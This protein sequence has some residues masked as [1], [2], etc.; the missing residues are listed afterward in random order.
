MKKLVIFSLTA[1]LFTAVSCTKFGKNITVK[2]RVYNPITNEGYEGATVELIRSK[3]L[4]YSGGFKEV[5]HTT[6][7]Q[8]GEFE[9][10]A[11]HD[12]AVLAQVQAPAE[13]YDLG[14][15]HDGKYYFRTV[16]KKGKI[17]QIDYHLVPYGNYQ[18]KINNVNCGGGAD[19]MYFRKKWLVTQEEDTYWS[20][21]RIGCYSYNGDEVL[22]LPMG[23]YAYEIKVIRSGVTSYVYDTLVVNET[24]ISVLNIEY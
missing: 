23:S 24:G 19:T 13:Y 18:L 17:T 9:M 15:L 4:Q 21:P 11:Y 14:W 6:T 22:Q 10:S 20:T 5:K 8:N 1:V 3:Y 2:G 12:G 16:V 7:N